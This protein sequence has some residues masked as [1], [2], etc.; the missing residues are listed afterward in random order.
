MASEFGDVHVNLHDFCDRHAKA[1]AVDLVTAFCS[2]KAFRSCDGVKS[3][4]ASY[5]EF[6]KKFADRFVVHFEN[7]FLKRNPAPSNNTSD[8]AVSRA[9]S[10]SNEELSD[11]SENEVEN[12]SPRFNQKPFFRRLSFK[13]LRK[14]KNFFRKQ[15]SDEIELSMNEKKNDKQTKSK[16]AKITV[17]CRRNG[18][19]SYLV[20]ENMD[21]Q[22]KWEKCRLS[23]STSAAGGYILVFYCP[24]KANKPKCG[25]FCHLIT[26]VRETTALEMPDKENTFVVRAAHNAEYVIEAQSSEDRR[27]WVA[28]LKYCMRESRAIVD[29]A[30]RVSLGTVNEEPGLLRSI[31]MCNKSSTVD[32]DIPDLPPR[33]TGTK[34]ENVPGYHN[35]TLHSS[36]MDMD[37]GFEAAVDVDLST[38]LRDYPWFHGTLV[39]SEATNLVQHS[40]ENGHG[41]F[42]VRQSETRK[43]EFVL[44]FNFHGRAKHLR[45]LLNETKQCCV[46]HLWFPS[47][48]DALEH[49]RQNSIPL[50]NGG[51]GDVKLTEYIINTPSPAQPIVHNQRN[52][53]PVE[54][55]HPIAVPQPRED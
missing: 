52:N 17:E 3:A 48:F 54:P 41:V 26:E 51:V 7:E 8:C 13:G 27:D 44:T 14:G 22:P 9:A 18:L 35:E 5:T 38:E 47:I 11:L 33:P 39:R 29:G 32:S 21:G 12:Q 49:F 37:N 4:C 16:L 36:R 15:D 31:A 50:E 34:L 40:G 45:L 46:Q 42:L 53:G 30:D 55:R 43:G 20:A 6:A 1:A 23:L 2:Y 10:N 25:V 19:A 24:P 28:T